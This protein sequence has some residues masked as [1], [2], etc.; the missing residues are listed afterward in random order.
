M[1]TRSPRVLVVDD[2]PAARMLCSATLQE[3]GLHVLEASDGRRGLARAR[4]DAPDL[5]VTDIAMPGFSGFELAE[6]LRRDTLTSAIPVI[7]LSGE[8]S[9]NHQARARELG[10]LAYVTKPF[11]PPTLVALVASVLARFRTDDLPAD[12]HSTRIRMGPTTQ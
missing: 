3:E 4:L 1:D 9:V 7:F 2:D 5:V 11:D 8:T 12:R 6:A 10:A